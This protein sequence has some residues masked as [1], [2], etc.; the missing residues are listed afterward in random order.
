MLRAHREVAPDGR[1]TLR[2]EGAL[3]GPWIAEVRW[4]LREEADQ[5]L[6]LD[7]SSLVYADRE[8]AELLRE[9]HSRFDV[10]GRSPF[11]VALLSQGGRR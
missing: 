10:R 4:L 5:P 9:L 8:G 7:L 6:L 3:A 11:V 2:L 1:T